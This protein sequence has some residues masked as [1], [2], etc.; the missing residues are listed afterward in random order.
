MRKLFKYILKRAYYASLINNPILTTS[1][2][3]FDA[4]KKSL[5]RGL[6]FGM[7]FMPIIGISMMI[8]KVLK[9]YDVVP[10]IFQLIIALISIPLILN[11]V[12]R[13]LN[14]ISLT[15]LEENNSEIQK[16]LSNEYSWFVLIFLVS[17]VFFMGMIRFAYLYF[18]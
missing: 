2:E 15:E 17:V 5:S 10:F 14:S 7:F 13:I 8:A 11:P 9:L 3:R 16:K 6:S 4:V 18:R 12:T 1:N